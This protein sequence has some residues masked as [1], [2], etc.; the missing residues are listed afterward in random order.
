MTVALP[1]TRIRRPASHGDP[2]DT[3]PP[4]HASV[5]LYSMTGPCYVFILIGAARLL[6]CHDSMCIFAASLR[7]DAAGTGPATSGHVITALPADEG[8]RGRS[9]RE[10]DS[11][12]LARRVQNGTTERSR[13]LAARPGDRARALAVFTRSSFLSSVP[14]LRPTSW[15][16]ARCCFLGSAYTRSRGR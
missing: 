7:R 3:G 15:A 6:F 11:E 16:C 2:V 13:G 10:P 1:V 4:W 12:R 9:M 5:G 14:S 8:N